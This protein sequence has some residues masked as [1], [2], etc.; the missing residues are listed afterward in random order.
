MSMDAYLRA[1]SHLCERASYRVRHFP[2]QDAAALFFSGWSLAG[3]QGANCADQSK[4]CPVIG[5]GISRRCPMKERALGS[6]QRLRF[7]LSTQEVL[8]EEL[9]Q[10]VRGVILYRPQADYQRIRPDS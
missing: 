6:P 5:M 4:C 7:A 1:V 8:V 3:E 9:H 10:L 2:Y